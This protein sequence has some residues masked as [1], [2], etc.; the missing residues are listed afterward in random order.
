LQ[1][2]SGI[3][4]QILLDSIKYETDRHIPSV[5]LFSDAQKANFEKKGSKGNKISQARE[6]LFTTLPLGS[7][8]SIALQD[9]NVNVNVD[10]TFHQELLSTKSSYQIKL[11]NLL[12]G[13]ILKETKSSDE[14]TRISLSSLK[15]GIY[16]VKVYDLLNSAEYS[17]KILK[18][19]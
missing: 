16:V 9:S 12:S 17:Q 13:K 6:G 3:N 7:E 5:V 14:T 1:V 15:N 11:I 8:V 18:Q 2:T 10:I 4:A 19:K